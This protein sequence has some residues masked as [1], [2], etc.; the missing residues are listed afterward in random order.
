MRENILQTYKP[1]HGLLGDT[2]RERVSHHTE[3]DSTSLFF[4]FSCLVTRSILR[5][6]SLTTKIWCFT[7]SRDRCVVVYSYHAYL[8]PRHVLR[9]IDC[10]NNFCH[11][12]FRNVFYFLN[13]TSLG[14]RLVFSAITR[15]SRGLNFCSI[16]LSIAKSQ[17][18]LFV[19]VIKMQKF[20]WNMG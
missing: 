17:I 11:H 1:Q 8:R 2:L 4:K 16:T 12:R 18:T 13:F 9:I 19:L 15:R 3:W 6:Y 10:R 20:T 14:T 7:C 5:K